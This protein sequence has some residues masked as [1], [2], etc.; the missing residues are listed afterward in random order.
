MRNAPLNAGQKHPCVLPRHTV[1]ELIISQIHKNTLH[2]GTQLTLRVLREHYWVLNARTLVRSYIGKCVTCTRFKASV[3]QQFMAD[4]PAVRTTPSPPFSHTGVDYA[5]PM[6]VRSMPGRGHRSHKAYISVFVCLAT[7][8]I[9]LELVRDY[10][11]A[12]FLAAFDRFVSRRGIP[13]HMY[14]DNGTTF[15]GAEKELL[16]TFKQATSSPA[17]MEKLALDGDSLAL[18]ASCCTSLW[19]HMGGGREKRETPFK[20]NSHCK[21]TNSR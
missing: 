1:S 18:L 16:I 11:S 5:G 7:R 21:H 4:L 20:A 2:G 12:A 9:H 17:L 6:L 19:R 13:E 3:G 15:K 14:S 10:S 8:G